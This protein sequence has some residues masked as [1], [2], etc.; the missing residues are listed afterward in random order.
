MQLD[1]NY[2]VVN[3]DK[4]VRDLIVPMDNYSREQFRELL[5]ELGHDTGRIEV[6]RADITFLKQG[7]R[8]TYN[9]NTAVFENVSSFISH[10]KN[11][12]N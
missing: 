1:K 5:I 6:R 4:Q 8:W 3:L 10:I 7:Q 12:L 9:E 11:G 2:A